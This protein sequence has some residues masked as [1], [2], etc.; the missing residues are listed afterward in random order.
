MTLSERFA[1]YICNAHLSPD[2]TALAQAIESRILDYLAVTCAASY[3]SDIAPVITRYAESIHADPGKPLP[4]PV[5]AF[6]NAAFAHVLDY[7][8]G[9]LW[10]G[11]HAAGPVIGSIFALAPQFK[12]SGRQVMEAVMVGYEVEYRLGMALGKSHI[13]RCFHGSCTCGAFGAAAAAAKIMNLSQEQTTFALGLAG[14][15]AFGSRQPLAE[16]Q[17][18]KP[19][20]VGFV[21]ERGVNAAFLAADANEPVDM[22]HLLEAARLEARKTDR[23]LS[24]AEVRGWV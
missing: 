16:G 23:P 8:D 1:E 15:A 21:A 24:E 10:A 4:A 9:H 2:D 14:L 20:Q 3:Y 17:M 6:V 13:D 12:P 19:V 18:S 5:Q 11:I 22:T 7:D